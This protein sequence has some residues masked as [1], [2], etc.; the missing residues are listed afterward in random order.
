[1]LLADLQTPP[2]CL[3]YGDIL[4]KLVQHCAMVQALAVIFASSR[5]Q[6]LASVTGSCAS[7][8]LEPIDLGGIGGWM[9]WFVITPYGVVLPVSCTLRVV[10]WKPQDVFLQP[11]PCIK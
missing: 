9:L 3:C 1:M 4:C 5:Q 11:M 6:T 8:I 7:L 2:C 10:P